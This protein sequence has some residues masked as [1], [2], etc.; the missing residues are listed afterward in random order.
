MFGYLELGKLNPAPITG[1]ELGFRVDAGSSPFDLEEC[2]AQVVAHPGGPGRPAN[3]K[4]KSSDPADLFARRL[5]GGVRMIA[6]CRKSWAP[7]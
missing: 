2:C 7:T 3:Y 6:S 5:Y 4:G 1:Y